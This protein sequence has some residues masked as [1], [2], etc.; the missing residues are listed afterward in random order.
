MYQFPIEMA[1]SLTNGTIRYDS[2]YFLKQRNLIAKFQLPN[3][4]FSFVCLSVNEL[5]QMFIFKRK[6]KKN[7]FDNETIFTASDLN[8]NRFFFLK[9]FEL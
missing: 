2:F 4:F 7:Y 1:I 9:Q 5:N 3:F 8:E 6:E